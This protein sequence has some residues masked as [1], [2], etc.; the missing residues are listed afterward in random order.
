MLFDH[1]FLRTSE[2]CAG[3]KAQLAPKLDVVQ[4]AVVSAYKEMCDR[5]RPNLQVTKKSADN[6]IVAFITHA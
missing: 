5:G 1:L 6:S 4:A 3:D 2:Y